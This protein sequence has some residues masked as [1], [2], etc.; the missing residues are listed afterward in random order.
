PY[1]TL[2]RSRGEIVAS[3][4]EDHAGHVDVA[5]LVGMGA[6]VE[7]QRSQ[8]MLSVD[9]EKFLFRFLEVADGVAFIERLETQSLRSKQQH[10]AGDGR[11]RYGRFVK[12]PNRLHLGARQH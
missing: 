1:T 9:D 11:L 10:R 2:F 8:A 5:G 6:F 12:V 4:V 3:A 7:L